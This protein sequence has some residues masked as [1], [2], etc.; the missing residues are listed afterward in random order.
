[1]EILTDPSKSARKNETKHIATEKEKYSSDKALSEIKLNQIL[2]NL[3]TRFTPKGFIIFGSDLA[4]ELTEAYT[5]GKDSETIAE[6]IP[7]NKHQKLSVPACVLPTIQDMTGDP[8]SPTVRDR[9]KQAWDTLKK[10]LHKI[11]K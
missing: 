9:K 4:I 6:T 5:T 2:N 7:I 1:M 8:H 10:F 11:N 3:L